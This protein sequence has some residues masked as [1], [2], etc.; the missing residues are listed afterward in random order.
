MLFKRVMLV[1]TWDQFRVGAHN[2]HACCAYVLGFSNFRTN[3][4]RFFIYNAVGLVLVHEFAAQYAR[5][6]QKALAIIPYM[7]P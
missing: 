5:A 6:C 3:C 2:L 4:V 7:S 1:R